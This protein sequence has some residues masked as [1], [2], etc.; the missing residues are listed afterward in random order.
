MSSVAPSTLEAIL[1]GLDPDQRAA[2]EAPDGPLQIVAPAGSGKTTTLVARLAVLLSRGVSAEQIAL[3]TF[4]RDAATE[5]S[6][7]IA[8]RLTGVVPNAAQVEVRT[9]HA[10]GRQIL[11]STGVSVRVVPDRQPLL[12]RARRQ[13][14]ARHGRP[15]EDLPSLPVLEDHLAAGE[16]VEPTETLLAEVVDAYRSL[17]A[18]QGSTDF[19]RLVLDAVERLERDPVLRGS[20]QTRFRHL[21]VD[22]FQDI[23]PAQLRLVELLALPE[24]S[25]CVVGDDD[26]TIYAW[27][28]ADVRRML[29]F[30]VRHPGSR[31]VILATNYRC[32]PEVVRAASRLVSVNR[33]R[34]PKRILAVGRPTD[35]RRIRTWQL[36]GPDGADELAAQL[37]TWAAP[38]HRVAILART[39]SGLAPY[40]MAFLRAGIP[41][42]TAVPAP[43]ES[44][45]VVALVA[46]LR[47]AAAHSPPF[48]AL[49]A[50]RSGHGWRRADP[51]DSL[52]DED[53]DALDAALGWATW[54]RRADS[55]LAAHDAALDRLRRLRDPAAPIE[56]TTI[57]GSKGREWD[58]VAVIGL[59]A[60]NL[61]NRRSVE[62]SAEP[63]RALEEERRLAYVAITRAR[64]RLLLAYDPARPSPFLAE[65]ASGRRTA[66]VPSGPAKGRPRARRPT[67]T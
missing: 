46:E 58:T 39:R 38:D 37:A 20:W 44:P 40:L 11:L 12:R 23:D 1:A 14:A 31:R 8:A 53:H 7:R 67:G 57:H 26:Q 19:D 42:A 35:S 15:L 36:R 49:L 47:A 65:M 28:R 24:D 16:P 64:Q 62:G 2:A 48:H 56:L 27:R 4:N 13:V 6:E 59:E 66:V 32:P 55:Y 30:P 21:L 45:A 25:L 61:P 17:L 3:L 33:E 52:A 50:L 34:V 5:L 51:D 9:F 54:H 43:I 18:L 60:D 22:E 10:L 63:A 29:E 41:H